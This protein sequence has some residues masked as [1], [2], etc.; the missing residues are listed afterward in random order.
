MG[1]PNSTAFLLTAIG[2]LMGLSVLFSRFAGRAGI[3]VALLFIAIGALAGTDGVGGIEFDDYDLSFRLGT[4]ALALIL[5]DGG[6]NTPLGGVKEGIRAASVLATLGVVLTAAFVGVAAHLL[7]MPWPQA[8]LV[9]AIVS[10]TDAAA[11][12]SILRGSGIHLKRRVGVT[13]E[14]ESGLNDPLAVILTMAMTTA[15]TSGELVWWRLLLDPIIHL[16]VGAALG[17]GVGFLG[18]A[19]LKRAWLPAGGLY[20]VFTLA[21]AFV[22]FGLPTL[23]YGSGFLAVYVAGILI[24]NANIRYRS[25]VLRVHDA[26]AWFAQVSMFIMLGLL[27]T[28]SRLLDVAGIGLGLAVILAF[29]ARPL[30]A[31][32]CLLPFKFKPKERLFISWVGLRGAVPIVLATFPILAGAA[33]AAEIFNIVFFIV[34]VGSFIPGATVPWL[35]HKLGL[36]AEGPPVPSAA[37]EITSTQLLSGEVI[38]FYITPV[39]AACGA[40][41]SELPFPESATAA[42]I[43][44]GN[45]LVAPRG[46]TV[47][48]TGDHVYVFCKPAD[49]P[50]LELIFGQREAQ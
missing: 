8:L 13:L 30:A 26:V 28:P 20:P 21:L 24:G 27:V 16:V 7:G 23:L 25:G 45:D 11:V 9:G 38:G 40:A 12:F 37:L 31:G 49:L 32:V 46:G 41:I 2:L 4:I 34:V 42:M 19:L 1:E 33:G 43:I 6:L 15:V 3:P 29:V 39:S 10:S 5:F 17:V 44:R 48:Q 14:L 50:F 36:A 18:R 35:T 22:A 47:L